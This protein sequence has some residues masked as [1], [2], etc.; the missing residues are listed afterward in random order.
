MA[1]VQAVDVHALF[2]FMGDMNG[3][4]QEW[5]C[6]TTTNRHFVA[7]LYSE[8]VSWCDQLL[9]GLNHSRRGTLNLLITDVPDLVQVTAVAPLGNSDHSSLSTAISI[10]QSLLNV[11]V[12][13]MV[14]LKHQVNCSAICGAVRE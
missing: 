6:S 12:R 9:I 2:K 10:A 11:C 14:P 7:A 13:R 4:H 8:T 5:M 1:A 3:H